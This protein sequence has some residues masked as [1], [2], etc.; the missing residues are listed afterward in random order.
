MAS[1]AL[2]SKLFNFIPQSF[3][4]GSFSNKLKN[5]IKLT[6]AVVQKCSAK[7]CVLEKFAKLTGKH[8]CQSLFFNKVVKFEF[9]K[10]VKN[11]FISGKLP[12]EMK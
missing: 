9:C 5:Q 11:T 4:E 12:I 8:L 6:E 10:I 1:L 3:S 7:K 2:N